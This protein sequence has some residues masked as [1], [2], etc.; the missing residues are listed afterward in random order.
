MLAGVNSEFKLQGFS[1]PGPGKTTIGFNGNFTQI[2]AS[3]VG[4]LGFSY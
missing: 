1:R 3:G 4:P 2:Q